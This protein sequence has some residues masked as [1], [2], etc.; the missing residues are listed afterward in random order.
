MQVQDY[1]KVNM[2]R[3]M[4]FVREIL[5]KMEQDPYCNRQGLTELNIP[6]HTAEETVYHVILLR[7]AGLIK[8]GEASLSVVP[9]VSGLTWQGHEFL[10]NI[11][12]PGIWEKTKERAKSLQGV[13]LGI[14]VQIAEAEVKKHFGLA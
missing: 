11:K 1:P 9:L 10:A 4:D 6:G 14:L 8:V 2:I 3:D 5:F 12:D 13:A 7:D